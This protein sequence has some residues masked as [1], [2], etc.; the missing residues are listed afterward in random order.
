MPSMR[1]MC[2]I[3]QC[4]KWNLWEGIVLVRTKLNSQQ[5][6]FSSSQLAQERS[7]VHRYTVQCSRFGNTS[8]NHSR[9]CFV[10]T[11]QHTDLKKGKGK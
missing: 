3:F 1:Y 2:R 6:Y 10:F 11:D 5:Y 9:C 8:S 7:G 4:M